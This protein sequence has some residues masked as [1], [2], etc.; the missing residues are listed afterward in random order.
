[1]MMIVVV[2]MMMIVVVVMPARG[3]LGPR[4]GTLDGRRAHERIRAE[5]DAAAD[6]LAGRGM[7]RQWRILDG[8][9]EFVTPHRFSGARQGFIDV[10]EHKKEI[11]GGGPAQ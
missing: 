1:M 11:G 7:L 6:R 8:L 5:H 2:M 4:G 10:G 9:A 3:S